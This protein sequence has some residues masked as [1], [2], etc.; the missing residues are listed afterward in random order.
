MKKIISLLL[1]ILMVV[2][3]VPMYASADADNPLA[4]KK[5]RFY[6]ETDGKKYGSNCSANYYKITGRAWTNLDT[7]LVI[8]DKEVSLGEVYPVYKIA[9]SAFVMDNM[10]SM[11]LGSIYEVE[12]RAF[13]FK[14][15][16]CNLTMLYM[17]PNLRIIGKYAFR[18]INI[19]TLNLPS[20]DLDIGKEAF[21]Y[22]KNLSLYSGI[23]LQL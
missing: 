7:D 17:S 1:S 3:V 16:S 4:A 21:A 6:M 8:P 11:D 22:C 9:D 23:W 13:D 20:N 12:E 19:Y 15:V 10:K 2:S 5:F 18:G 14:N